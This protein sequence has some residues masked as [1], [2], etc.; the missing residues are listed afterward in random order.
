[1]SLLYTLG[2]GLGRFCFFTFARWEVIGREAVPPMG[3]LLVVANHLSYADPPVLLAAMPR[4]V[5]FLAHKGLFQN[6]LAAAA[7][8]AWGAHP[9]ARESGDLAAGLWALRSLEREEAVG[10]F[11]EGTRSPGGMRKA[12]SG[13]SY[14]A[15]KSQTP[16]LPVGI[17][18]T[19]RVP[20]LWRIPFAFHK[21]RVNIG[22]PFTLPAIEGRLERPVLD[23]LTDMVMLRIAALLP[24]EYRGVYGEASAIR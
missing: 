8:R 9:V 24:V 21:I 10:L 3:R 7:F 13:I 17:T 22:P 11:P 6:P 15:M 19:E 23:S 18:G 16:I 1:M 14:L 5:H 2:K 4:V 20:G 12:L